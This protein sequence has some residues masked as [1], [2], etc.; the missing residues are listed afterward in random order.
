MNQ[1][2]RLR[3]LAYDALILLGVLALITFICRLWPV[4]LLILLGIFAAIIRLLFLSTKKVEV[5]EEEKKT[6][7]QERT[8]TEQDVHKIA[9]G[10]IQQRVTSLVLRDYPQAKWVWEVPDAQKRMQN[11]EDVFILLNGAGG[12]RRAKVLLKN[13]AVIGLDYCTATPDPSP[14]SPPEFFPNSEKAEGQKQDADQSA[15]PVIENYEL[16]AFEWVEAHI[17]DLNARCNEA[18]AKGNSCVL[19]QPQEL[20]VKEAWQNLCEEL[21][22][23]G[24]PNAVCA[25]DGIKIEIK[26]ENCGKESV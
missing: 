17:L 3:R 15:K 21:I 12:Y 4:L 10:V 14:E 11:G 6:P 9:Y 8:Y 1:K 16:L 26:Q 20:P 22:R 19:L 25:D 5:I 24:L 23:A 13:M 7:E 2:E 18:I